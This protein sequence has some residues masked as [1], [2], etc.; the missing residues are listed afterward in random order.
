MGSLAYL[1]FL[2]VAGV[3]W[4]AA[5]FARARAYEHKW[6]VGLAAWLLGGA[7][8]IFAT[9]LALRIDEYPG[10]V[11]PSGLGILLTTGSLYW[12]RLHAPTAARVA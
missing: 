10:E 6:L 3:G 12:M 2:V 5:R 7:A 4:A 8:C 11:V 9:W 1:A